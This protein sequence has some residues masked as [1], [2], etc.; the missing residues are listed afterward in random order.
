MAPSAAG[1]PAPVFGKRPGV[2][3]SGGL[4]LSHHPDFGKRFRGEQL[5]R[6]GIGEPRGILLQI[7]C[8]MLPK[9]AVFLRTFMRL[10]ALRCRNSYRP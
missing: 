2:H 9:K 6:A 1:A 8:Q 3:L 5:K 7:R 10:D 4:I